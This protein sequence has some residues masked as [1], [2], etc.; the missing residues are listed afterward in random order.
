[1][2]DRMDFYGCSQR[3]RYAAHAT[4]GWRYRSLGRFFFV[5]LSLSL[6]INYIHVSVHNVR[7]LQTLTQYTVCDLETEDKRQTSSSEWDSTLDWEGNPWKRRRE[8]PCLHNASLVRIFPL[9]QDPPTGV[10]I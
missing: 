5:C 8:L 4:G 9:M 7:L 6:A 3:S 2:G 10:V 1:M